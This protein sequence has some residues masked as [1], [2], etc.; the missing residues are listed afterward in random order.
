MK[1]ENLIKKRSGINFPAL[2]LVNTVFMSTITT[3]ILEI[4]I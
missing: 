1:Y 4:L 2:D 3:L